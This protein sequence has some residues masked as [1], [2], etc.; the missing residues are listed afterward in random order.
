MMLRS[1]IVLVVVILALPG[2]AEDDDCNGFGCPT[3]DPT[4]ADD[5]ATTGASDPTVDPS[6]TADDDSPDDDDDTASSMTV[7]TTEP[8]STSDA[9][10]SDTTSAPESTS[11]AE[12]EST[13][14]PPCE[15]A[16]CPTLAECFGIGIWE[17]CAQYC[18]AN[19]ANCVEGGC[20]G[21]TVVYYGDAN[22]CIDM[23]SNG[24]SNQSCDAAFDEQGGGVSFG[25]CCCD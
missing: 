11:N 23:R 20:D 9:S 6:M 5:A 1:A 15:G 3:S 14:A 25:R 17:N 22:A 2:C 24:Q 12:E 19:E 13:T 4:A 7:A 10:A 21:A 18:E 8:G 16:D